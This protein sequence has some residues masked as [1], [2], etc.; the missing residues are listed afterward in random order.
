[1]IKNKIYLYFCFLKQEK[2]RN[3]CKKESLRK[4]KDIKAISLI[5]TAQK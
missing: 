1:M 3:I 5:N 2:S 4:E